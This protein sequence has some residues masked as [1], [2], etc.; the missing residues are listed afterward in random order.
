VDQHQ[1]YT[2]IFT[3]TVIAVA[4][5]VLVVLGLSGQFYWSYAITFLTVAC[6]FSE[7]MVIKLPYG[8]KLTLSIIFVLLAIVFDTDQASPYA[9]VIGALQVIGIGALL[10]HSLTY[11]KSLR[12]LWSP[13]LAGL[14]YVLIARHVPRL[15]LDSF[16][17]PAVAG[18]TIVFSLVS[19]PL[20]NQINAHALQEEKLP[21]ADLLYTIFMAPIAL[22]VYYFVESRDLSL[23]SLLL[24]AIPLI[25]VLATF[26]LYINVDTTHEPGRDRPKGRL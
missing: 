16:H 11:R 1:N 25:G 3:W 7:W 9:Q 15:V 24:L 8:D 4:I 2:R 5:A 18:Y 14:T 23:R 13:S 10:G 19:S 12:D 20:I 22:I 17:L 21:K 26:R 6:V